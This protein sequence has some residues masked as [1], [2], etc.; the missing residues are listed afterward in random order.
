MS[1]PRPAWEGGQAPAEDDAAR[2]RAAE[3]DRTLA[4]G[5]M[6]PE[7]EPSEPVDAPENV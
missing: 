7:S 3:A 1:E 2:Q 5:S 6:P 4:P